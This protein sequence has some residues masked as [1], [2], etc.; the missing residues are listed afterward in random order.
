VTPPT[1]FPALGFD[2]A[3]GLDDQVRT[4]ASTVDS[5]ARQV[6]DVR[7]LL[8][9]IGKDNSF[10]Q[11]EAAKNFATTLGELPPYLDKATQS[12]SNAARSMRGWAE[13]LA[14]FKTRAREYERQAAEARAKL[15][16]AQQNLNGYQGKT[17][18]TPEQNTRLQQDAAAAGRAVTD[19]DGA[20]QAIIR[21]AHAL[22][23][24]HSDGLKAAAQAIRHAAEAAPKEPGFWDKFLEDLPGKVWDWVKE[25]KYLIKA[26]GDFCSDLSAVIGIVSMFLPPPADVIGLAVSGVLGLGALAA[27]SIAWAAGA[28]GINAGTLIFDGVAA[29]AGAF[30]AIGTAGTRGAEAAIAEGE[31]LGKGG[32]VAAGN[33]AR[34]YYLNMNNGSTVIG[35]NGTVAGST[36]AA[37]QDGKLEQSDIPFNKFV[38]RSGAQ[39]AAMAV[40]GPAAVGLYNYVTDGMDQDEA[41]R[42]A[43][44]LK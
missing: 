38:P 32:Q 10:W 40:T 22:A 12:N 42:K 34:N 13:A 17:G 27:H 24:E 2:P 14:G 9:Q 39:A 44:W 43:A 6:D 35:I 30:G 28:E 37:V 3:P 31:A 29:G 33:T 23:G 5:V 11:G 26:I 20:L 1:D 8:G 18:T 19:A 15:G 16:A 21:Q 36:N 25:H 41:E 4:L 7:G